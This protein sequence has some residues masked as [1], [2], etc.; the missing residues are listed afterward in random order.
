MARIDATTPPAYCSLVGMRHPAHRADQ[1]AQ[2]LAEL[3]EAMLAIVCRLGKG[4][5]VAWLWLLGVCNS[6]TG[7]ADVTAKQLAAATGIGERQATRDLV[8]VH[9]AGVAAGPGAIEGRRGGFSLYPLWPR[10]VLAL[11]GGA[12]RVVQGDPQAELPLD[13][14]ANSTPN[15]PSV[16]SFP[17]IDH[18]LRIHTNHRSSEV[19]TNVEPMTNEAAGNSTPR[20]PSMS[21]FAASDELAELEEIQRRA[22]AC[23]R[24]QEAAD[25]LQVAGAVAGAF[26]RLVAPDNAR[27]N[28]QEVIELSG[29]ILNAA[30]DAPE[31]FAHDVARMVVFD[32]TLPRDE[33]K[34]MLAYVRRGVMRSTGKEMESRGAVLRRCVVKWCTKR[35]ITPPAPEASRRAGK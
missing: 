1:H 7:I 24:S 14:Q 13:G 11:F 35:G 22:D 15:A 5:A 31:G 10:D 4:P 17:F 29:E 30:P 27:E 3:R 21:S 28:A 26:G 2:P 19:P 25:P 33:L 12:P 23:Q 16:S 8:A 34:R 18:G 20:G 32:C 6:R 9:A